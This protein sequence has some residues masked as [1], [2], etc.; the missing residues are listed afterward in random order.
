MPAA[1]LLAAAVLLLAARLQA[2]AA[3]P[4]VGVGLRTAGTGNRSTEGF[5]R[6]TRRRV[7]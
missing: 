7:E 6:Q 1:G 2:A 3:P 5:F 4:A